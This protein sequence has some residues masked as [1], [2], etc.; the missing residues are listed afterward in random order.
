MSLLCLPPSVVLSKW[1]GEGEKTL[2]LAFQLARRLAGATGRPCGLFIVSGTLARKPCCSVC[3]CDVGGVMMGPLLSRGAG[4]LCAHAGRGGQPGA[5]AQRRRRGRRRGVGVAAAA[6]GVAA[7]AQRAVRL[8]RCRRWWHRRWQRAAAAG[9]QRRRAS[10]RVRRHQP[11]AGEQKWRA[12]AR[13]PR[14]HARPRVASCACYRG[15]RRTATWRCS[16]ASSAACWCRCPTRRAAWRCCRCAAG[17]LTSSAPDWRGRGDAAE[18]AAWCFRSCCWGG[19]RWHTS[20][21]T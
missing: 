9:Q 16:A 7:A 19:R 6:H 14:A 17:D 15:T 11:A 5:A 10:V 1:S 4:V 13:A 21:G 18:S 8:A 2:R 20:W 12:C 3:M